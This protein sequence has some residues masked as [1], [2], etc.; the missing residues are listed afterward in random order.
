MS[1]KKQGEESKK[2][3]IETSIKIFAKKGYDQTSVQE[4]ADKCGLSQTNVFYHYKSK[5]KSFW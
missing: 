2:K 5:K 4:I 1:R 3:I